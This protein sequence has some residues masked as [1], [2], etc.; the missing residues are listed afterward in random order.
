MY[1]AE[2]AS[3]SGPIVPVMLSITGGPIEILPA[4]NDRYII[5]F[6][7]G[8]GVT[9]FV[10]P[11]ARDLPIDSGFQ[12]SQ[13]VTVVVT[14]VLH[15][16]MTTW[17]WE[18]FTG[19]MPAQGIAFVARIKDPSVIGKGLND[20]RYKVTEYKGSSGGGVGRRTPAKYTP[21]RANPVSSRNRPNLM[22]IRGG[23]SS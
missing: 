4:D 11:S 10:R 19:G 21:R 6:T 7:A 1:P 12:V 5:V 17:A 15:G 22:G 3:V 13:T 2:F 23:R 18:G 14:H 16:V 9:Y 20:E 8:L